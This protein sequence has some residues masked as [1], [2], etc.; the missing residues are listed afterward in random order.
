M[1][2]ATLRIPNVILGIICLTLTW[3]AR[4][5]LVI[6]ELDLVNNG[7]AP[8]SGQADIT[9][10]WS[11]AKLIARD[12]LNDFVIDS[13]N[14]VFRTQ[15]MTFTSPDPFRIEAGQKIRLGWV[16]F[17]KTPEVHVETDFE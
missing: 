8:Y 6:T 13:S 4:A 1:K 2:Q 10:S 7:S 5:N 16:R 3:Q 11:R 17:S 15:S 14:Q 12:A 9:L